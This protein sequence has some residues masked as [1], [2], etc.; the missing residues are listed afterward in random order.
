MQKN[1]PE[2]FSYEVALKKLFA[3]IK[4]EVDEVFDT[5]LFAPLYITYTDYQLLFDNHLVPITCPKV[6]LGSAEKRD[7]V[8]PILI[9]KGSKWITHPS[10]THV[11]LVSGD[12][13]F[14]PLLKKGKVRGLLVMISGFDPALSKD[15]DHPSF[16][17]E[18]GE[19]A[20]VSPKTGQKMVHYF[21]PEI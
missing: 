9:E 13:D 5:F 1:I 17:K 7:T 18:L 15:P 21:S 3:W 16:S 14:V 20:D 12:S 19:M 2:K 8:D 4:S 11:C 10:L 6:P